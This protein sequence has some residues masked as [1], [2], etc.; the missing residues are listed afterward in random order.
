MRSPSPTGCPT[1]DPLQATMDQGERRRAVVGSG[2]VVAVWRAGAAEAMAEILE[3][4]FE[5]L[6]LVGSR[7]GNWGTGRD[8]LSSFMQ[9]AYMSS[10][11]TRSSRSMMSSGTRRRCSHAAV[12]ALERPQT[13]IRRRC[14]DTLKGIGNEMPSVT[15]GHRQEV[16]CAAPLAKIISVKLASGAQCSELI[17]PDVNVVN[18]SPRIS[19]GALPKPSRTGGSARL[20]ACRCPSKRPRTSWVPLTGRPAA[21]LR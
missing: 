12:I 15:L 21:A 1:A 8:V 11:D 18:R 20:R 16:G 9:C 17:R 7:R 2:E 3:K 14:A 13:R 19:K 10:A 5:S 4:A 6:S